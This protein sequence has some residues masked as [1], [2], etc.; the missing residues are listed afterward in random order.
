MA[1][2]FTQADHQRISAAITRAERATRGEIYAVFARRS[3]DVT[4]V[5]YAA[6]LALCLLCGLVASALGALAG[7]ALPAVALALGQCI[8]A[9]VL[10]GALRFHPGLRDLFVPGILARAAAARVAREQFAAHNLHVTQGRTGILIFVSEAE[11]YAQII[12]DTGIAERVAPEAWSGMVD[13]LIR[14][15]RDD[16]LAD[17]LVEVIAE[18][19]AVLEQAF[20]ADGQSVNELPDRLVEI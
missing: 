11:H 9:I 2:T 10:L 8:G 14:A 19:G 5:S 4:P 16:R 7:H 15:A 1:L 6:A 3:A 20:P 12:A 17:G 13:T 18:A